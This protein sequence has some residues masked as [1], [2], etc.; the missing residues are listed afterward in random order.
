MALLMTGRL[1]VNCMT[2][3]SL[4]EATLLSCGYRYDN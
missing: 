2:Y 3:T 4:F 1:Y